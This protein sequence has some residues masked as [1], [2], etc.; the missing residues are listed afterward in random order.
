MQGATEEQPDTRSLAT[1]ISRGDAKMEIELVRR[2]R[3]PLVRML[4]Y[5][6]HDHARAED[7]AQETLL[8]V[9]L[10]LRNSEIEFPERLSSF[11]YQ[12]GRYC[13][14]GW[15]RQNSRFDFRGDMN[16]QYEDTSLDEVLIQAE[17]RETVARLIS[18][19]TV[20]RDRD[21]LVR[22]YICDEPKSVSCEAL[23]LSRVHFDRVISRAKSRLR[24]QV[25]I[26]ETAQERLA[27][28]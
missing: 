27:I 28:E 16:D 9:L 26:P 11:V 6:T 12:T 4:E 7:L 22:A 24:S 18:S 10:K 17:H 8:I 2:Y 20:P 21:L 5:L 13:W 19:V 25:L 23:S 1:A 14:L 3:A 15:Q